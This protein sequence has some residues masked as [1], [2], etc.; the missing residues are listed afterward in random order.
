MSRLVV[1]C[2][3]AACWCIDDEISAY[4]EAAL[5]RVRDE[6][7]VMPALW[8][9]EMTN[10]FRV[11]E[12]RSRMTAE[13]ADQLLEFLSALPIQI[14]GIDGLEGQR[15][16][17]ELARAHN[18]SAY[19]ATYLHLAMETGLPLASLDRALISAARKAKGPVFEPG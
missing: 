3:V 4:A 8:V 9:Y 16:V 11:A 5:D 6:G 18:L 1:D 2:S 15:G 10:V 13:Q 7:G 19:D 12:R 17:L 14:V